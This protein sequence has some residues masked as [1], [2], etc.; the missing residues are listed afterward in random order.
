MTRVFRIRFSDH[1]LN[2]EQKIDSWRTL[3]QDVSVED[4]YAEEAI[5]KLRAHK[6]PINGVDHALISER[7]ILGV[8]LVTEAL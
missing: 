8:N 1:L 6:E 4:G 7:R 3:E 2:E 5:A